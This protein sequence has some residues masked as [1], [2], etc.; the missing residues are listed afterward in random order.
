MQNMVITKKGQLLLAQLI[1]NEN[2]IDFTKV[3]TS[4]VDYSGEDLESLESIES[5]QEVIPDRVSITEDS[6]AVNVLARFDNT[7]VEEGYNVMAIGL[8]AIDNEDSEILY[9]VCIADEGMDYMPSILEG[10]AGISYNLVTKIG[11]AD[12]VIL[13]VNPVGFVSRD[14]FLVLEDRVNTVETSFEVQTYT[15]YGQIGISDSELSQTDWAS[16][17]VVILNAMPTDSYLKIYFDETTNVNTSASLNVD[18]S[19]PSGYL[20]V[21]K[22]VNLEVPNV[23]TLTKGG[24]VDFMKGSYDGQWRG[25]RELMF[26]DMSSSP[27]RSVQRGSL[28]STDGSITNL[29][30]ENG[31]SYKDITISSIDVNK[32][33]IIVSGSKNDENEKNPNGK[34]I[35]STTIRLYNTRSEGTTSVMKVYFENLTWQVIEYK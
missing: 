32:S 6:S 8:Y 33:F 23:F 29:P 9:A 25:F 22:G 2:T 12:N 31:C 13:E 26:T 34:I 11:N 24:S 28:H 20:E 19:F 7:E 4:R 27:I 14:E 10:I 3:V 30:K 15:S 16:N 5:E 17:A 18:V 1:A 35:N 21:Q